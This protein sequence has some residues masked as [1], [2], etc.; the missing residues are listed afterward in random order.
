MSAFFIRRIILIGCPVVS[1]MV[2]KGMVDKQKVT[3]ITIPVS[4]MTCA[5]CVYHVGEALEGVPQVEQAVVNLATEKAT[6]HIRNG[7]IQKDLLKS[8]IENA[9][10]QM[11]SESIT[12]SIEGMTCAACVSHIEN[13]ISK[14]AGVEEAL[15]NLATETAKVR[16]I[17]G[18]ESISSIRL[19]ITN[20]G[21]ASSYLDKEE[22][23]Y[24]STERAQRLIIQQALASLSGAAIIMFAMIPNFVSLLPFN[25]QYLAFIIATVI[26]LWAGSQ[27]YKSSLS[28][29]KHRTTN[30]NTLIAV[31]TSAAY[32]YSAFVVI[33]DLLGINN[34]FSETHFGTSCAIIGMV[35]LGRY[36]ESKSRMRATDSIKSLMEIAPKMAN[37]I[38]GT[39]VKKVPVDDLVIG[40]VVA[41]KPGEIIPVD[42]S[43]IEGFSEVD[44]SSL[45]GESIPT[46]K[47]I[48]D[49]VLTSTIN[50]TGSIKIITETLSTNT[51]Y[52]KIISLIED[53]QTSKAPIQ[54]IADKLAALLVPIILCVSSLT[55]LIWMFFGPPPEHSYATIAAVAVLAI[56]LL[57]TS[58]SPRDG[59][60]SR[61]PSSA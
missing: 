5:A 7:E 61:M 34:S 2:S 8:A 24:G 41:V 16:Y 4:G 53:T 12:L 6:V 9:G 21:Y 43:V 19:A 32:L 38:R 15:V 20:A 27:F 39:E 35:L 13:S 48:G 58:P 42:G 55:F 40:D 47:K 31:G 25:H 10:Y 36:L 1:S 17:P 23:G 45:T 56:C 22:L 59:L 26:Q 60:L 54:R 50:G 3:S 14:L 18:F 44:E 49:S 46:V 57:Y 30:M 51:I 28:A 29:A 33:S 37:T 11:G 52:S